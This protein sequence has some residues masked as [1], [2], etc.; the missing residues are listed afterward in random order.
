[1]KFLNEFAKMK[2]EFKSAEKANAIRNEEHNRRFEKVKSES[3]S[4]NRRV[5]QQL[6][7]FHPRNK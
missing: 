7:Y 5:S 6:K 2:S 1:M 3:E 4:Q